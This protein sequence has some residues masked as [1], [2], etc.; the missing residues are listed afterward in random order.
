MHIAP[1]MHAGVL[2]CISC[3]I[4]LVTTNFSH[5]MSAKIVC[6]WSPFTAVKALDRSNNQL[7]RDTIRIEAS[8]STITL[9]M[10][11]QERLERMQ[12]QNIRFSILPVN[13][14]GGPWFTRHNKTTCRKGGTLCPRIF[15]QMQPWVRHISLGPDAAASKLWERGHPTL[16]DNSFEDLLDVGG[17]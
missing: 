16:L 3:Y 13:L 1:P 4:I 10:M 2:A 8:Q 17:R 6:Y 15:M 5:T 7:P 9:N 12:T 11:R 14:S